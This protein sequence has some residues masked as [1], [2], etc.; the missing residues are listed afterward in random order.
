MVLLERDTYLAEFERLLLEA[1]A[2]R[3]RLVFVGGEAGVGKTT[4]VSQVA[5]SARKTARVLVGACAIPCRRLARCL[6]CSTSPPRWA[7]RSQR[8]LGDAG[9]PRHRILRGILAE[10][11]G[12]APPDAGGVRG[13]PLG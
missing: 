11:S 10:L 1:A 9:Q 12:R 5:D 3:G 2:G 8:L 4:F 7:E 6:P 13:R